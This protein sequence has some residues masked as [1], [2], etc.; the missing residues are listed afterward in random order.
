MLYLS[1]YLLDISKIIYYY[2]NSSTSPYFFLIYFIS[3][4]VLLFINVISKIFNINLILISL[5]S[6][7]KVD[8]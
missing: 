7:T 1:L 3:D 8:C 4:F 5:S 6:M 2:W